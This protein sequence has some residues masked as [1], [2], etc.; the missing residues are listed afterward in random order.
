MSRV[1]AVIQQVCV[2]F[3]QSKRGTVGEDGLQ[4]DAVQIG[5]IPCEQGPAQ[6]RLTTLRLRMAGKRRGLAIGG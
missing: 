5:D 6:R 4:Q 1:P 3:Q 2:A